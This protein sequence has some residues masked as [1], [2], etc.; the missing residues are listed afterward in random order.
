MGQRVHCVEQPKYP[1]VAAH[2]GPN[3]TGPHHPV[4]NGQDHDAGGAHRCARYA[5]QDRR[6]PGE[7]REYRRPGAVRRA[8]CSPAA[9][10]PRPAGRRSRTTPSTARLTPTPASLGRPVPGETISLETWHSA[11][12]PSASAGSRPTCKVR[13]D[14]SPAANTAMTGVSGLPSMLQN[15]VLPMAGYVSASGPATA[16][17]MG[18]I[19][20]IG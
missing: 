14:L 5:V 2:L 1:V 17:S 15:G 12:P 11:P 4:G 3:V 10:P 9:S 7:H 18:W 16:S 13:P 6:P 8:R 20:S 19:F